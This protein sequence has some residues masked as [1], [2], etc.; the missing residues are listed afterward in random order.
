E[1]IAFNRRVLTRSV[2]RYDT[3]LTALWMLHTRF[4]EKNSGQRFAES[5]WVQDKYETDVHWIDLLL[6]ES[7]P[8]P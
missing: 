3:L 5:A 7:R 1:D 2:V 6:E 8:K 4:P